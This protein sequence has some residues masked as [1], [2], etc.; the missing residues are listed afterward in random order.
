M[1]GK[2]LEQGGHV[3][4]LASRR[5]GTL[6]IG[7][8]ADL[9]TRIAAHQA[10]TAS[11]FTREYNVHTLVWCEP[12]ATITEAITREKRLKEWKRAWKIDLIETANPDWRDLLPTL[13]GADPGAPLPR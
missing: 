9:G 1:T 12:H 5:N 3:Y 13:L 8:T 6:Y 2:E 4:I 11:A 7:V 10:G